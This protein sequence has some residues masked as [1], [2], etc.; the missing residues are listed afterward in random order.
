MKRV[1][2]H[3]L[4]KIVFAGAVALLAGSGWFWVALTKK[5]VVRVQ[6]ESE[7]VALT[8][9]AWAE[10]DFAGSSENSV[11]ERP[12]EQSAGEGWVY[13]VFTP[14]VIHYHAATREFGVTPLP[15]AAGSEEVPFAWELLAVRRAPYRVQLVGYAGRPDDYVAVFVSAELPHT[16]LVRPGQPLDKLD[17]VLTHFDVRKVTG[18]ADDGAIGPVH[19]IAAFATLHDGR[20]GKDVVLDGRAPLLTDTLVAV[21][22]M[23]AGQGGVRELGEGD[24]LEGEAANYRIERIQRNPPEVVVARTVPGVPLPERI[25]VRPVMEEGGHEELEGRLARHEP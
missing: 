5:A 18:S 20:T 12:L 15:E 10:A 2:V 11:W 14:P 1:L 17:L 21:F 13:E 7:R 9:A 19:E 6:G 4:E 24:R 3:H 22:R 23:P 25:V 16:L 8:G